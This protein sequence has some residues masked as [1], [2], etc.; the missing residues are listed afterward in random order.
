[1]RRD[2]LRAAWAIFT[3]L[4][5]RVD[6]GEVPVRPYAYGS[7]GPPEADELLARVGYIRPE[8]YTWTTRGGHGGGEDGG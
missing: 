6:A 8:S 4:L 7:R 2:E 3:P 5:E 1:M